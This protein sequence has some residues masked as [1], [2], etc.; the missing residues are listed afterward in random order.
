M[1]C[2]A[3]AISE[4]DTGTDNIILQLHCT[5]LHW[6]GNSNSAFVYI[7]ALLLLIL[8]IQIS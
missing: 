3:S 4:N 5:A 1:Y 6:T 2:T 7:I 8:I